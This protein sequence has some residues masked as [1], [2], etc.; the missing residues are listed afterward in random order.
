MT[1]ATNHPP[2]TDA[3]HDAHLAHHF[4]NPRQQFEA[5]VQ[6]MWL[7]LA[8]EIVLF[9]GLFCA[10]AVYRAAHP[11]IFIYG[12]EYLDKSLGAIN[13]VILLCSSFT[14]ATAVWAVQHGRQKLLIGMLA[15]TILGACGFLSI[16][17]VEYEHK[18]KAGLLW[19]KY[20]HPAYPPGGEHGASHGEADHAAPAVPG[21]AARPETA[22]SAPASVAVAAEGAAAD[23]NAAIV[24]PAAAAAEADQDNWLVTPAESGP[25]GLLR[26][27]VEEHLL[28]PEPGQ[29]RNVQLFFAIYFGMT[30]LHGVHVIAGICV[31]AWLL[32]RS[33]RGDFSPQYF[34]PVPM[35][36]LYWHVVD[37]IWIYL[38]PLLY[39]IH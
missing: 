19:G 17:Y 34:T 14:M 22:A 29:V 2:D 21:E 33:A 30:G 8:T 1:T 31:I 3:H 32:F 15:L 36:G 39:L 18:W 11:E 37:L 6:G 13:T 10:Y 9:G 26:P 38:F 35:V 24:D 28:E 5:S 27:G 16:K 7:F 23:P 25:R 20:Y 12:H 4:D